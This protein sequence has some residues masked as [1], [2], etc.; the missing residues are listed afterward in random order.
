MAESLG[1]PS[2]CMALGV[3]TLP[4]AAADGG[5]GGGGGALGVH[6]S[7]AK[8]DA[9]STRVSTTVTVNLCRIF[10]GFLLKDAVIDRWAKARR[11]IGVRNGT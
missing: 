8:A 7:P 5:S 4:G 11:P 1:A 3:P 2:V 10:T 6:M 9:A